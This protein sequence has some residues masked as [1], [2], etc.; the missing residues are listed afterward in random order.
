VY[1]DN[2]RVETAEFGSIGVLYIFVAGDD[3]SYLEAEGAFVI[4]EYACG[5]REAICKGSI[6]YDAEFI[7]SDC[8]DETGAIWI[9]VNCI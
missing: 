3:A 7:V 6:A 9:A 2:G 4:G 1:H 8:L 5:C